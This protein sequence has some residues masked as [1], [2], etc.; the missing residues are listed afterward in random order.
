MEDL[1]GSEEEEKVD[2]E[3]KKHYLGRRVLME[4]DLR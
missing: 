4:E 2:E 3:V 1:E